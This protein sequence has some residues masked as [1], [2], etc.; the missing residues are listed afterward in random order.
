MTQPTDSQQQLELEKAARR[1]AEVHLAQLQHEYDVTK[2]QLDTLNAQLEQLVEQRTL[3]LVEARDSA[4]AN[5]K[6][7][8]EFLANMSHEIRTPLNGMLGMLQA[9]EQS[10]MPNKSARL[11]STARES[12]QLLIAIINDILELTK[13]ETVGITLEKKPINLADVVEHVL[14]NFSMAAHQKELNLVSDI[15]LLIPSQIEGDAYRI[16]QIVGNFVNNAIKFTDKGEVVLSLHQSTPGIFTISV[17]DTGIGM[18]DKQSKNV[19]TAFTQGDTST[20]RKY[21]GTGLGLCIASKLV[22]TMGAE[23]TVESKHHEGSL[24]SISLKLPVLDNTTLASQFHHDTDHTLLYIIS[25]CEHRRNSMMKRFEELGIHHR[26]QANSLNEIDVSIL[27]KHQN[28]QKF[29]FIDLDDTDPS[30]EKICLQLHSDYNDLNLIHI[31]PYNYDRPTPHYINKRIYKPLQQIDL[32]Q[33][34]ASETEEQSI[35]APRDKSEASFSGK[36]V[37]IVDDNDINLQVALEL[38]GSLGFDIDTATNGQEAINAA[39]STHYDLVLM[40]I[41]MPIKDGL[42]ACREIR[43][44]GG[45]HSQTPI[46][47]MTANVMKED[48]EKSLAAGMNDH[49]SKPLNLQDLLPKFDFYL[50][51][52]ACFTHNMSTSNTHTAN[53]HSLPHIQGFDLEG[54]ITRF[55]GNKE[56]LFSMLNVFS[57]KYRDS[58]KKMRQY[59][60]QHNWKSA[61][62]LAHKLKGTSGNLGIEVVYKS[63]AKL[64]AAIKHQHFDAIEEFTVEFEH[65]IHLMNRGI[66]KT[67]ASVKKDIHIDNL[68]IDSDNYL[69]KLQ[70]LVSNIETD[71][72]EVS[73]DIEALKR[74]AKNTKEES[75]ICE[76]EKLFQ[77]F[78]THKI[79]DFVSTIQQSFS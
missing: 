47:A 23:I 76:I 61:E 24:F 31:A 69:Q 72:G 56:K 3:A 44:L 4:L 29:I 37:L 45:R 15:S 1:K 58:D 26:F 71:L 46:L 19:F 13:I 25:G 50:N 10:E 41:Q 16:Q 28:S 18:T 20:T 9:L 34:S 7:K 55:V 14:L 42:Q 40:D 39:T 66:E 74:I 65:A 54:A 77:N 53:D 57:E 70:H 17:K 43:S 36:R 67:N 52:N 8:S 62:D 12:G 6:I 75:N 79:K 11:V 2:Q 32:I 35:F 78:E 33:L 5:A 21:G 59:I 30:F 63:A 48:H 22:Q 64:E 27:S 73:T 38:F 68:E 60:R 49:I 51:T